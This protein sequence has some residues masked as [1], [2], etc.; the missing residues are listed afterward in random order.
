MQIALQ[1]QIAEATFRGST[2]D[3][4]WRARSNGGQNQN[5]KKPLGLPTIPTNIPRPKI[6][7]PKMPRK[8][9]F[10]S[11][12]M[13]PGYAGTYTNLQMVYFEYPPKSPLKSSHPKKYLPKYPNQKKPGIE[14]FK[15]QKTFDHPCHLKSGVSKLPPPPPPAPPP[16][17]YMSKPRGGKRTSRIK[18]ILFWMKMLGHWQTLQKTTTQKEAAFFS[19]TRKILTCILFFSKKSK[20]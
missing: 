12:S 14:N 4:K 6:N 7:P 9:K 2:L 18:G 5:P 11:R 17:P 13:R 3:F 20:A 8:M 19:T 15:P 16:G 1:I 10:G